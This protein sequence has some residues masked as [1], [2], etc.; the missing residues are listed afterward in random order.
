[1]ETILSGRFDTW[2]KAAKTAQALLNITGVSK[3]DIC[4]FYVGPAGHH[5]AYP[6][7]GDQYSD[8]AAEGAHHNSM[9]GGAIGAG[10]AGLATLPAGPAAIA[11]GAV[12]GAYTGSLVGSLQG[13]DD[14]TDNP[15]PSDNPTRA[16]GVIIAIRIAEPSDAEGSVVH[17]L[18]QRGAQ[19]IEKTEGQWRNGEWVDFDPVRPPHL[20]HPNNTGNS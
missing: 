1:M 10:I 15:D 5:A 8:P 18:E 6:I 16:S 11:T 14:H 17:S 19:D 2:D 13:M 4:T 3:E 20:L 9:L 12:V 7:G